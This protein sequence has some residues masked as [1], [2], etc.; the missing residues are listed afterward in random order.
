M[1]QSLQYFNSKVKSKMQAI[2]PTEL[3]SEIM[4]PVPED[5]V[6]DSSVELNSGIS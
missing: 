5:F 3:T 4:I 2:D 1:N 6:Y